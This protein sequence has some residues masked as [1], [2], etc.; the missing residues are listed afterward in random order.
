[1]E[2]APSAFNLVVH[3]LMGINDEAIVF[4]KSFL[5]NIVA[6]VL[7]TIAKQ[8]NRKAT[9]YAM[10]LTAAA[11]DGGLREDSLKLMVNFCHLRTVQKGS[12]SY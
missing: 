8:L 7:S 2:K 1:M 9:G 12:H 5:K 4:E 6:L 11:R 10:A 3:G